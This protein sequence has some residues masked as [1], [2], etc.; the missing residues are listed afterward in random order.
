MKRL[1]PLLL[2]PFLSLATAF[3]DPVLNS[4]LT[5]LSGRYA[6][7]Y[8]DNAARD[9][10]AAVTTWSR[11]AGTQSQPTYAGINEIAADANNVYLRTTGLAFHIMGPWYGGNGNLFPNYPSNRSAHFRLTRNP[12]IPAVGSKDPTENGTIGIFVDG[13]SMFDSRDAFSY[14]TSSGKDQTPGPAQ[15]GVVGDN[16]WNRNAYINE[17]DT[18]DAAFAHQAN[19][20]HHYHANPPGLRYLLGGSVDH[21]PV[22]NTYTEAPNGQHSAIIGWVGDGFPLYGPYGYSDP[23]DPTSS[24]RRMISG[25]QL[26]D[27]S[28]GSTNLNIISGTDSFGMQTGRTTLPQWV[29]R[30]EG[31]STT[32]SPNFY[33]PAVDAVIDGDTYVLGRYLQDYAY[34]GDL[35]GF[36][37]YEGVAIDGAFNAATDFDLNEYNVRFCVTPEYPAGTWAYFTNIEPDG[38]PTFPYN[39][40]RYYFGAYNFGNANGT[41]GGAEILWEGGPEK[42]LDTESIEVDDTSGDVTLIWNSVEGGNY[43]VLHTDTLLA[44]DWSLL[45]QTAGQDATTPFTDGGRYFIDERHFYR[46]DL[47][48]IQPFDDAGFDYDNSVIST[49]PQNNVL[50]LILDDWGID[51]SELYNTE[52]GAQLAYMPNLKGLLFSDLTAVPGDTPDKGMLFTRGYAQPICSPTRATILTGRQPYQHKVGNPGTDSTLPASELTFPEIIT[53]DAPDYGLASFGKWHLGSGNTGPLD[54]GGWPNFSGTLQGG[55]PTY[56]DW[57]RVEIE[58]GV[59]TDAGTDVTT[60]ATTAQV[61]EAVSYINA[62]GTDPWVVWMGFNAPHDPFHNPDTYVTPT[63]GYSTNGTTDLDYYIKMLEALDHKIG[64]LLQSVDLTKTNIIVVGDNGTPGQ[65]DQLP[66]G[67]IAGAK[68]SINEGGIHVPF[69]ATGPDV[70]QTGISDKLVHVVD[71]FAT[72]LDITGVN[73]TAA[74][75]GIDIHSNSIVPIFKGTDMEDR[76]I[77]AEKFGLNPAEDGRALIMD[78]WPDFKLV[79]IQD[80]TDPNDVPVYQMY[81]LGANGVEASTLT[82]PPA[83]GDAWEAAYNAMV[84][85]DQSLQ[86]AVSQIVTVDIDLPTTGVTPPVP[87]L[88]NTSNGNIVRPNGITIGG[89]A[90][91]WDTGD[92]T[93]GGVT[94]SAARVDENGDPDQ[95]SVVA[96]IDLATTGFTSGQSYTIIVTFPG[97]GGTNRVYTATNQFVAP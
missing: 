31:V 22:A 53:T 16:I 87:P 58:N 1:L 21:D 28:N 97:A 39:M 3:A 55:V 72:I 86:P 71:L 43:S 5:D 6:R 37:F 33:G 40:G 95:Y 59:L 92:I 68:G 81:L 9:A 51:S 52:P 45:G 90:A 69:F 25:Y 47:E 82:T 70:I 35:T 80:V 29:A 18:F 57:R 12:V 24:V 88:I 61:D 75:A 19:N 36:D 20:N 94:T 65:V 73:T 62:Q 85:K 30:N 79:S 14:D 77:I 27:G 63:A 2:L 54:T 44:N 10:G 96:E 74:T 60:Y 34:K 48:Y 23:T 84:A 13:V 91:T 42:H 83:P 76:C 8:P 38:T 93:V 56:I 15:A 89:V 7:I 66:A 78:D 17:S 32:L 46:A 67:G 50:L 64:E 49:G 11:G 4:W 26:R 41:P